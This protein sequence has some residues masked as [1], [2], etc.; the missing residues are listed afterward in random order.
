MMSP[1]L[2]RGWVCH[3]RAR[4]SGKIQEDSGSAALKRLLY[5][6]SRG[7][8]KAFGQAASGALLFGV[9]HASDAQ[10]NQVGPLACI[11]Y[12]HICV[13]GNPQPEAI[14]HTQTCQASDAQAS[15]VGPWHAMCMNTY[16]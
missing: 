9:R 4:A 3:R 5:L 6:T 1:L 16:V 7:E 13:S 8:G 15:Q 11:V 10:A 14:G 2:I 12:A